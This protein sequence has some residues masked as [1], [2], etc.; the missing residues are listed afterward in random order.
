[1]TV[2]PALSYNLYKAV[3]KEATASSGN[4]HCSTSL[5]QYADFETL[6]VCSKCEARQSF[7]ARVNSIFGD[8]AWQNTNNS[9]TTNYTVF[10]L[11][12]VMRNKTEQKNTND[13]TMNLIMHEI[14]NRRFLETLELDLT[15]GGTGTSVT[16]MVDPVDTIT[17]HIGKMDRPPSAPIFQLYLFG[18]SASRHMA[19]FFVDPTGVDVENMYGSGDPLPTTSDDT[20]NVCYHYPGGT[21]LKHILSSICLSLT[22]DIRLWFNNAAP[23][24]QFGVLN[25]TESRCSLFPCIQRVTGAKLKNNQFTAQYTNS[26]LEWYGSEMKDSINAI[27]DE[28][29]CSGHDNEC[30]YSWTPGSLSSVGQWINMTIDTEQFFST[31]LTQTNSQG[32]NFTLLFQKVAEQVSAVLRTQSNPDITNFTG[33]V[34]GTEIYV[35]VNWL[36]FVLPLVLLAS[37][38]I[39]LVLSIWDSSRKDYLF[40]NNILA[41]I[42]FELHGWEPHEYG[43]DETWTRHSMRNVE[44]RAERMVA[45]MQLPHEGDGGLRLKRE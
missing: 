38:L 11:D 18:R 10:G 22:T 35:Q 45:R 9:R 40:K 34:Y 1:M 37:C 16:S 12:G 29:Y 41:A 31:Y 27:I 4:G 39:I 30:L 33:T 19:E 25:Y 13:T 8:C 26:N 21:E 15:C 44:K 43:V 23:S 20:F 3:S 36:W 28:I 14:M 2:V 7:N 24:D 6:A 32:H 17:L 5:C 42:A